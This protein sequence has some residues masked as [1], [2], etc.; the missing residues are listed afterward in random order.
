MSS[1]TTTQVS[2]I[3]YIHLC[4]LSSPG[5]TEGSCALR[6]GP[7]HCLVHMCALH[8]HKVPL[9]PSVAGQLFSSTSQNQKLRVLMHWGNPCNAWSVHKQGWTFLITN[10]SNIFSQYS[11]QVGWNIVSQ[12]ILPHQHTQEKGKLKVLLLQTPATFKQME[13]VI[14]HVECTNTCGA[15]AH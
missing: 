13:H 14:A 1:T 2:Q 6:M 8:V 5:R 15:K 9:H 3:Y 4:D 10:S 12:F 7:K 11:M